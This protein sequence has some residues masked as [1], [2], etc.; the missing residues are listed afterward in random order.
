LRVARD[1]AKT[2]L[3]HLFVTER[4]ALAREAKRL[5]ELVRAWPSSC[6]GRDLGHELQQTET[7]SVT[8]RISSWRWSHATGHR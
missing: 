6:S 4:A 3:V 8:P 5:R 2:D 7:V 1:A